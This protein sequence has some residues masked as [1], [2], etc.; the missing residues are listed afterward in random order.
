MR[1]TEEFMTE[2]NIFPI[3]WESFFQKIIDFK[4]IKR[5]DVYYGIFER[6]RKV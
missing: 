4:I 2:I 3:Y 5:I 1:R 6:H